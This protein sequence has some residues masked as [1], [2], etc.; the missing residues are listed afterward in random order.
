MR[1]FLLD[2][3]GHDE[4]VL[5]AARSVGHGVLGSRL[6]GDLVGSHGRGKVD[7][8]GGGLYRAGVELVELG[9]VVEYAVEVA[10][11]AFELVVI[12]FHPGQR[13]HAANLGLRNLHI[14]A[15]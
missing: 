14:L 4:E 11:H 2:Y 6:A 12:Q 10:S 13:G 8:L 9:H 3:V 7:H 5:V 1:P 15:V